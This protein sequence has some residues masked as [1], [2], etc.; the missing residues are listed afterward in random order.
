MARNLHHLRRSSFM[1]PTDAER[2][3]KFETRVSGNLLAIE[4]LQEE[5][6]I[7]ILRKQLADYPHRYSVIYHITE[8]GYDALNFYEL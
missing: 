5:G 4:Q 2:N 7:R 6:Y 1:R 3:R 8:K